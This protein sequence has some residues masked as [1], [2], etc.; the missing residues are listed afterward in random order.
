MGVEL[1]WDHEQARNAERKS[2]YTIQI[3]TSRANAW[4]RK[5]ARFS[6]TI[7]RALELWKLISWQN[8]DDRPSANLS[9]PYARAIAWRWLADNRVQSAFYALG[10][11]K[12]I[13]KRVVNNLPPNTT[14][15]GSS[16]RVFCIAGT[17][18]ENVFPLP[19]TNHRGIGWGYVFPCFLPVPLLILPMLHQSHSEEFQ[20]GQSLFNEFDEQKW[21]PRVASSGI[22]VCVC[23]RVRPVAVDEPPP[24]L[25]A[26]ECQI[27][28]I[29]SRTR[30]RISTVSVNTLEE[31]FSRLFF[32]LYLWKPSYSIYFH[33][34]KTERKQTQAHLTRG[35]VGKERKQRNTT[36][37]IGIVKLQSGSRSSSR[38][39]RRSQLSVSSNFGPWVSFPI[40]HSLPWCYVLR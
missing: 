11:G 5:M 26:E 40:C 13:A 30:I 3:T 35:A 21:F 38:R 8:D 17:L 19:S 4:T 9:L 23:M 7:V 31:G 28:Q 1:V 2:T 16:V 10:Q 36:E 39:H 6:L 12:T 15:F 24:P 32:F 18:V 29:I 37:A 33:P 27:G 34:T 14:N 22:W 25:D 20:L